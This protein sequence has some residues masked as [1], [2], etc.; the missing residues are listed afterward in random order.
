LMEIH[1]NLGI[2]TGS[3]TIENLK[4][5]TASMLAGLPS[6]NYSSEGVRYSAGI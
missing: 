6:S 1:H 5:M 3:T 2:E 4:S